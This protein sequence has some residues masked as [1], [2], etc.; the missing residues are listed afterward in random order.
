MP[1]P[2]RC[3]APCPRSPLDRMR[4]WL[5]GTITASTPGRGYGDGGKMF[6]GSIDEFPGM[7]QRR[8]WFRRSASA[9][10]QETISPHQ[11]LSKVLLKHFHGSYANHHE[12]NAFSF[13]FLRPNLLPFL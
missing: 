2:S 5:G 12:K 13:A 8:E 7:P 11:I 10:A 9:H 3:R 4:Q 1:S 6:C